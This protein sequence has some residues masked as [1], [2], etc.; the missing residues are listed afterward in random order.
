MTRKS[1]RKRLRQ[2]PATPAALAAAAAFSPR[3]FRAAGVTTPASRYELLAALGH[4]PALDR[5]LAI[6]DDAFGYQTL[7]LTF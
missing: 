5:R 6:V 4:T 2:Q 7:A 3:P 1:R